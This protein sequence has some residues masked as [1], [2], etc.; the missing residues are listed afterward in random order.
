MR[1]R[2]SRQS[3]A[4]A[5]SKAIG[6]GCHHASSCGGAFTALSALRPTL[7]VAVTDGT[8]ARAA[9]YLNDPEFVKKI[10]VRTMDYTSAKKECV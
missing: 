8:S 6:E 3:A 10:M 1:G 2:V 9:C 7:R 4:M 5:I